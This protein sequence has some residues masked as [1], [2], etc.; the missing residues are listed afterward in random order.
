[1]SVRDFVRSLWIIYISLT[2]CRDTLYHAR[3]IKKYFAKSYLLL[4]TW[5][6]I[7]GG[8]NNILLY[9]NVQQNTYAEK[10]GKAY[11]CLIILYCRFSNNFCTL[12]TPSFNTQCLI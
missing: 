6:G 11:S 8:V 1:M 12:Y 5:Q 9:S 10:K 2:K 4:F 3:I 7:K